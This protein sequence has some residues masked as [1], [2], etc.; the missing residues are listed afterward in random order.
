[1][2]QLN[3][4][5]LH[6]FWMVAREGSIAQASQKLF[7]GMPTISAQIKKL[8][9]SLGAALFRRSGRNLVLTD[10]GRHVFSYADEIFTLGDDLLA[11]LRGA[12]PDRPLPFV[13]GIANVVPKLIAYR[14]L[15]PA[16]SL[17]EPLELVCLEDE[18][19]R[20]L[21]DLAL[22][23]LDLVITDAPLP[24]H[25][26]V[27]AYNHALGESHI[28]IFAREDLATQLRSGFPR[29]LDQTPFL[30]PSAATSMARGLHAWFEDLDIRPRIVGRF[31][32]SSLLKV[33]AGAGHGA[34]AAPLAVRKHLQEQ[35]GT[36]LLE[37][38]PG[39]AEHFYAISV[40]RRIKHPAVAAISSAARIALDD[41]LG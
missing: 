3:Y 20:L 29:S 28:G 11:S 25:T 36:V 14:L 22:H 26:N 12:A 19:P 32:N 40:E 15:E 16:L 39:I 17:D 35:Y 4:L 37:A 8:E 34:F 30:M 41:D 13:V 6:Y 18:P 31:E 9:M 5:H 21:A 1:M 24:P 33:F 7:I 23:K 10:L 27:K 2:S 38:V